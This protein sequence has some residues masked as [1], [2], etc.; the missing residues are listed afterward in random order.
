MTIRIPA[1]SH[2]GPCP[3]ALAMMAVVL[4]APPAFEFRARDQSSKK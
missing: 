4:I 1:M 3:H 2:F